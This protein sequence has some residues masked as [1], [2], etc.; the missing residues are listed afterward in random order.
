MRERDEWRRARRAGV[1]EQGK[2][3]VKLKLKM[4]AGVNMLGR[5]WTEGGKGERVEWQDR[6]GWA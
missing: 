5:D 4:F 6:T 1:E 2:G 3:R